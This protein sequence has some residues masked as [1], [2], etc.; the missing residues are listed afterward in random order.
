MP[1]ERS[2]SRSPELSRTR[3]L[4]V[5][6]RQRQEWR[7]TLSLGERSRSQRPESSHASQDTHE[8]SSTITQLSSSFDV[9]RTQRQ[10]QPTTDAGYAN[11][12]ERNRQILEERRQPGVTEGQDQPNRRQA[13]DRSRPLPPIDRSDP[14]II[15]SSLEWKS[16]E[17]K[18]ELDKL[19]KMK[20][21]T[22]GW[23]NQ[24]AIVL[25]EYMDQMEVK[26]VLDGEYLRNVNTVSD[27][28]KSDGSIYLERQ[29]EM[30]KQGTQ[31]RSL[32]ARR[33]WE[34]RRRRSQL[35]HIQLARI[36]E[37]LNSNSDEEELARIQPE[38]L[39]RIQ[40]QYQTHVQQQYQTHIQLARIEEMLN[41]NSDEE[42]L[43]RIQPEE[44][45]R[46]QQQ[47]QTH[48][49]LARIEEILNSN[50]DEE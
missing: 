15:V 37:I 33:G 11:E 23:N 27:M 12:F 18:A 29:N 36:E 30:R 50:S 14:L 19:M 24:T 13:P 7:S 43:A 16:E 48:V 22:E 10:E 21:G 44:L 2:R 5:I 39:A 35:T 34:T 4:D 40:Q 1:H 20:P 8:P 26:G 3:E 42:E 47:Y 6:R 41:S 38:E 49:Q 31:A 25:Q 28:L 32:V 17:V 45:A 9:L 46:I